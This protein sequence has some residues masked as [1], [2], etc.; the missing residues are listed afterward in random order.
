HPAALVG[1]WVL[2]EDPHEE[3]RLHRAG[4]ERVDADALAGELDGQLATHREDRSFGGRVGDLGGGG[5]EYGHERGDVD[6][7]AAARLE[8]VRDA[9]LA[10]EV[11]ALGV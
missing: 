7:R 5:A 8:E 10:A 4:A 1:G 3:R 9:V 11:D 6:D 2:V